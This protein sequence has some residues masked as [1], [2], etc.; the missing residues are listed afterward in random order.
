M[1]ASNKPQLTKVTNTTEVIVGLPAATAFAPYRALRLY[2]L[3]PKDT[4]AG[5]VTVWNE[6]TPTIDITISGDPVAAETVTVD[7]VVITWRA[8]PTLPAEAKITAGNVTAMAAS[9][10][11]AINNTANAI[12]DTATSVAGIV[13][14]IS[15]TPG[16]TPVITEASTNVAAAHQANDQYVAAAGLTKQGV[17]FGVDG[18]IVN[19]GM[20][21]QLSANETVYVAWSPVL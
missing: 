1:A 13:S 21:V 5:T 11:V 3:F 8:A 18:V 9:L 10:A 12:P 15:K 4:L 6:P 17:S 7:G 19:S 2:G 14:V 20:G 16:T